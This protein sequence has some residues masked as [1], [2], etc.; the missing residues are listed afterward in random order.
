MSGYEIEGFVGESWVNPRERNVLLELVGEW[1]DVL[2]I[3]TADGVTVA[4]LAEQRPGA[5][6]VSI[7]TFPAEDSG[8]TGKLGSIDNW[9]ANARQNQALFIGNGR[10]FARHSCG[11]FDIVII[12]GEHT[13]EAC[14]EDIDVAIDLATSWTS[15]GLIVLH[16]YNRPS[17]GVRQAYEHWQERAGLY[18]VREVGS[19]AVVRRHSQ[20]TYTTEAA[21]KTLM[22]R[23]KELGYA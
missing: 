4:W 14:K 17:N 12:D 1:D 15:S 23:L 9:R 5:H 11:L 6:F 16:D 8:V 18:I 3:G 21:D 19:M 7:D 2:E 13:F 10:Q 22:A 20:A